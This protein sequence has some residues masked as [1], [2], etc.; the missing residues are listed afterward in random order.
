[1]AQCR[2]CLVGIKGPPKLVPACQT[3][4]SAGMDIDNS[5]ERVLDARRRLLEFTLVN[6]PIDCPI[7]DKAGE[8][9]LQKHYMDYD[10][11]ESR[12]DHPKVRK[13]KRVDIGPRIV[14]DDERCI[15]CTR[16][17]RFM[18]EVAKDDQLVMSY[19]GNHQVLTTAPGHK[20]DHPYCLNVV[21]ICPV[22]A[23]TDKDFRFKSRVWELYCTPTV[24]NGCATGCRAEIHHKDGAIYRLVPRKYKDI[25]LNLNWMCDYGRY[26]YKAV[27]AGRLKLPRVKGQDVGWDKALETAGNALGAILERGDGQAVGVVLGADATNE[28]NFVAARLAREFL[29]TGHLYLGAEP[30]G[31]GDDFL[32][33][34]DPNPNKGGAVACAGGKIASS[35]K[36]AQDLVGSKLKALYVVGDRLLLPPTAQEKLAGLELL[37]IQ[38]THSSALVEQAHVVLPAAAWAEVDGTMCNAAGKTQRLRAAVSPLDF[39]RPHWQIL[40]Q[41]ARRA[42]L[43]L[44]Y[45]SARSLFDS[46]KQKVDSMEDADWGGEIP[47]TLL[48]FAA[49]RG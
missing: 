34:A 37:I 43:T 1:V 30:D 9:A 39:S 26:S 14:L 19:R 42:G 31:E 25:N 20:L 32:R 33:R 4:I 44:D 46:L 24:C 27:S 5:S 21:D 13:P 45:T 49:S 48:R 36:L 10:H 8:C 35:A 38:A 17:V 22:G 15:L 6:H 23:L 40:V 2:Q 11:E 16:C 7:C 47:P 18:R 41:V 3:P 28:D 12:V 29:E